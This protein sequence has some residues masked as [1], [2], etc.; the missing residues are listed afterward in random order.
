MHVVLAVIGDAFI[1]IL[2]TETQPRFML[3]VTYVSS[4]H[5]RPIYNYFQKYFAA[6]NVKAND[7]GGVC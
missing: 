3:T 7:S 5:T 4:Q 2:L 1:L 6:T